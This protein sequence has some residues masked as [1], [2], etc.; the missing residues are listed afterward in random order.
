MPSVG[1][2]RYTGDP[3]SS[4]LDLVRH[5]TGDT[6]FDGAW[7]LSDAEL[8]YELARW[9]DPLTGLDRCYT[10]AAAAMRHIKARAAQR[11][12]VADG[13]AKASLATQL[14]HFEAMGQDLDRQAERVD[15]L[16]P[17]KGVPLGLGLTAVDDGPYFRLGMHDNPQLPSQR[18]ENDDLPRWLDD[19]PPNFPFEL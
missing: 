15:G 13:D 11:V 17:F 14:E 12:D 9:N 4:H 10:T 5:L 1:D 16:A 3:A 8:T 19:L 2:A 6:G 18:V 7:W